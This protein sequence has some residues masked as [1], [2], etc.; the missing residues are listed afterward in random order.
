VFKILEK[1][2]IA[3]NVWK[4]V[5]AAPDVAKNTQPGQFVVL[6]LHERG[7]RIP[8][9]ISDWDGDAGTIT[10]IVQA[11]GHTTQQLA[12]MNAG[13]HIL[14]LLGPLGKP[15]VIEPVGTVACIAGGVGTAIIYP[16]A[17]RHQEVGNRVL[18]LI[19]ARSREHLFYQEELA[20]ISERVLVATD[21]GSYGHKGFVTDLLRQLI[22]DGIHLDQVIA[23]GPIPMME[24][25]SELTKRHDIKTIVSLNP[26]MVDG[27]GM[28]GACRVRV[29]DEIKFCCIDG[30]EFD[31][32]QVDFSSLLRRSQLYERSGAS[33]NSTGNVEEGCGGQCHR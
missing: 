28:C 16:E 11:V 4:Y 21:D 9:S 33:C 23:V 31:A 10:L 30:P 19:G 29:G 24:A 1:E 14:D 3:H 17:R 13:D 8:I 7:E 27:T 20:A 12:E 2:A 32:H 18:T 26:I 22:A 25:V 6:R 5:I 15:A